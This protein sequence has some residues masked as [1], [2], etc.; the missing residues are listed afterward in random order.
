MKFTEY[1]GEVPKKAGARNNL[2]VFLEEFMSA[3][4]EVAILEFNKDEYKS[5]KGAAHCLRHAAK[6]YGFPVTVMQRKDQVFLIRRD[7]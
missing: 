7:M 3:N 6:C 4:V 1:K 2:K 5:P